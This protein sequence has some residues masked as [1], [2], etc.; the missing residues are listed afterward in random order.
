MKRFPVVAVVTAILVF[1]LGVV[2]P[3]LGSTIYPERFPANPT[4]A[5]S[6]E[7]DRTYLN[8]MAPE[9]GMRCVAAVPGNALARQTFSYTGYRLV[10]WVTAEDRENW[11]RIRWA[12]IYRYIPDDLERAKFNRILTRGTPA[13]S[14]LGL[15][16]RFGVNFVLV[17]EARADSALFGDFAQQ[18]FSINKKS[19]T[20]VRVKDC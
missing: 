18:H 9:P 10:Q 13:E 15:A 16:V 3:A 20:L 14:W 11:A 7:G 12:D 6:L 17:P 2:S 8:A 5:A 4:I 19:F 1:G